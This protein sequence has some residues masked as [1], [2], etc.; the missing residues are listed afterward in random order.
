[1][2]YCI[3]AIIAILALCFVARGIDLLSASGE[4]ESQVF[5]QHSKGTRYWRKGVRQ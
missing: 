2:I 5:T 3:L 1:M 4:K